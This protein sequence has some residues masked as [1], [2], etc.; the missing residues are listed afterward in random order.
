MSKKIKHTE[1]QMK[2][3]QYKVI[4]IHHID[5]LRDGQSKFDLYCPIQSFHWS[6]PFLVFPEEIVQQ[7][8]LFFGIQRYLGGS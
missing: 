2:Y 4:S 3:F 5:Q 1:L 8:I 7:L 6:H